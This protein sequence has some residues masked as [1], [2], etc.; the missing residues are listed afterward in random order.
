MILEAKAYFSMM[1]ASGLLVVS[2]TNAMK[3]FVNFD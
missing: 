1:V 3:K 2:C